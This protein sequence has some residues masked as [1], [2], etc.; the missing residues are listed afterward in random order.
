MREWIKL[1]ER[2]EAL[3]LEVYALA[4]LHILGQAFIRGLE[5]RA[6]K[7]AVPMLGLE[8][9]ESSEVA[10]G[11]DRSLRPRRWAGGWIS[12]WRQ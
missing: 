9:Q 4:A 8:E 11:A 12:S 2:N 10:P 3:D 6:A 1:R 7:F 5:A